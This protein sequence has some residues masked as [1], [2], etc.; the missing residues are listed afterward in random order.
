MFITTKWYFFIEDVYYEMKLVKFT[1]LIVGNM[2]TP[3]FCKP[4]IFAELY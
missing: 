4:E 2:K 3:D 1:P